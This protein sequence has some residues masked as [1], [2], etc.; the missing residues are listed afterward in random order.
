MKNEQP[1]LVSRFGSPSSE[2]GVG[3]AVALM[4]NRAV[5]TMESIFMLGRERRIVVGRRDP[6]C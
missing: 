2:A 3:K 4:A 1:Y 5:R 6:E